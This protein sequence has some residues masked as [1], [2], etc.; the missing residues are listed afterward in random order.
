MSRD[1]YLY[2]GSAVLINKAD[3]R[4]R[5]GLIE[6][7]RVMTWQRAS[8]PLPPVDVSYDGFRALHRHLFQD[9]YEWAGE[10]RIVDMSLAGTPFARAG[11]IEPA[12]ERQFAQLQAEGCLR[13]LSREDFAARAAAHISEINAVH[14]FRDG[15]GRTQRLF[16]EALAEQAGHVFETER[17]ER[18]SWR[19]AS[20]AGY[21][22]EY[23]PMTNVIGQAL[24][25]RDR[26]QEKAPGSRRAAI[27]EQYRAEQQDGKRA[28]EK[29]PH[30]RGG[31]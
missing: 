23:G 7:E 27:R 3:I 18:E 29:E 17:I 6:F 10:P 9:V 5:D 20:I 14:P 1:P 11:F 22:G 4:D 24:G 25:E 16:L 28:P 30:D 19:E 2:P 21:G 12:M 26:D 8:E 31:R 13:D 15:N